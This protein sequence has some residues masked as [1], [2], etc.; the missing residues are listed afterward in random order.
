MKYVVLHHGACAITRV[1]WR[2]LADGEV[3][4]ELPET[5]PGQHAACV[6]V[7]LEGDA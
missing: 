2:I 1:H 7:L 5:E 6:E 4:R 3:R